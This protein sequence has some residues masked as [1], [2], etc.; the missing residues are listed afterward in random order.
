M[1]VTPP[2]S[3][4]QWGPRGGRAAHPTVARRATSSRCRT[5]AST[6]WPPAS[7]SPR[8]LRPRSSKRLAGFTASTFEAMCRLGWK[9][10]PW[11]FYFFVRDRKGLITNFLPPPSL[12]LLGLLVP[13]SPRKSFRGGGAA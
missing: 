8:H 7:S 4:D 10:G 2:F 5:K 13:G 11:D 1:Q 3:F 9:G 12:L 6:S